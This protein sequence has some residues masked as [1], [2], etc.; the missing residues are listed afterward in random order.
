MVRAVILDA[1]SVPSGLQAG[2]Y[3]CIFYVEI[4]V[5][6]FLATERINDS[7]L[8]SCEPICVLEA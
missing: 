2:Q 1:R 7:L 3:H 5:E 4:P 8:I 6:S